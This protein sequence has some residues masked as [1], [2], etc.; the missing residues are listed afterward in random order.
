[1]R[2]IHLPAAAPGD[3]NA[4]RLC[5]LT[6]IVLCHPALIPSVEEA[7]LQLALEPW[8]ARLREQVLGWAEHADVLDSTSLM[9]H[10]SQA[11]LE[12][13][14]RR[15]LGAAAFALPA[16]AMREVPLG[17]AEARWRHFFGLLHAE[18]LDAEIDAARREWDGGPEDATRRLITLAEARNKL[19]DGDEDG[20]IAE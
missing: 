15:A 5:L 8:L 6:A 3:P 9:N 14:A 11:G 19:R 17:A 10:L 1:V 12:D 4:E 13:D 16:A 20:D 2:T 7:Y 18:R